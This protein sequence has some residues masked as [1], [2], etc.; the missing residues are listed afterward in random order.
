MTSTTIRVI[1]MLVCL[2]IIVCLSIWQSYKSK[3]KEDI[4]DKQS[5]LDVGMKDDSYWENRFKGLK[6]DYEDRER[7]H[8]QRYEQLKAE[9]ENREQ[10]LREMIEETKKE[11]QN[12]KAEV[13]QLSELKAQLDDKLKAANKIIANYEIR[14]IKMEAKLKEACPSLTDDDIKNISIE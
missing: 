9:Y 10:F 2:V 3:K 13:N 4:E 11:Y 1:F 12:L 7:Y 6:A 14:F 5:S 8:N